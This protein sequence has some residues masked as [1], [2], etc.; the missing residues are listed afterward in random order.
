MS[1]FNSDLGSGNSNWSLGGGNHPGFPD[2][3]A[4]MGSLVMPQNM[5]MVL[6][7]AEY[8]AYANGTFRQ[9]VDRVLSYFITDIEIN[10]DEVDDDEKDKYYEFF[11]DQVGIYKLLHTIGL[12]YMIY[13]NA[14]ISV[15]MPFT[16]HLFCPSKGCGLEVPLRQ[17]YNDPL[18][19]FEWSDFEF[20][21]KCPKCK[22][23]GIWG[24]IDRRGNQENIK[25]KR[26]N[27]HEIEILWD[28]VTDDTDFIWKIPSEYRQMITKG[29]LYHLERANWEVVQAVKNN[30]HLRFGKDFVYHMKEDAL[31]GIR[32]RGWGLPRILANFRQIWYVQVLHRYNEAIALDYVIPFRVITPVPQGGGGD[33]SAKDPILNMNMGGFMSRV[34]SML[35]QRRK[36]PASWFTLPFPVEYK[37]LGGDATQLAPRDLLDQGLEVLLN[38]MGVPVDL[39]KGS[40]TLQTAPA[41]LRLFESSWS[42]LAH[43]LNRLLGFIGKKISELLAWE[44][45]KVKLMRVTHADDLN[46]QMAKL[47]LMMGKQ[48]SQTTGLKS[49]GLDYKEETKKLLEE[50]VFTAEEQSKM[51][52]DMDQS[53]QMQQMTQG[54]Q[55]QPGGDPSQQGQAQGGQPAQGGVD[56]KTGQPIPPTPQQE[57]EAQFAMPP[58][59]PI[60][61][62]EMLERANTLAQQLM[63]MDSS[64]RQ[65]M[66]I[67]LKQANPTLHSITKAR[68]SDL[69]QQAQTAGGAALIQQQYGGS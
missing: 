5:S 68:I 4:D 53:A 11:R 16:R 36:D 58:N 23:N 29:N 38:N 40:L 24:H 10:D 52:E 65:S 35:K 9:A 62:S 39:M 17:V 20:H 60:T 57:M 12:D 54:A 15:L 69:R 25:I 44:P 41:A 8:I 14:F 37:A 48:I 49:V 43:N 13:G 6:R 46:R 32:N 31:A 64:Q 51:Q 30:N 55:Q 63:G 61:P 7:Y 22:Y 1:T 47:Q 42:H 27:P 3:W 26:W 66:M 34:Q 2:A 21:A 45:V 18:F 56:P 50:E 33:H 59:T 28:P 67:K 19:S